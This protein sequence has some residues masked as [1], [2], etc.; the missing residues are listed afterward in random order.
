MT[1]EFTQA[2]SKLANAEEGR[3]KL[4]AFLA[5]NYELTYSEA[6]ELAE[7]K[8]YP[9]V[10][11]SQRPDVAKRQ[12]ELKNRIKA[13]GDVNVNSIEEY[14]EV[15]ERYD[16]MSA[17]IEDLQK[18]RTELEAVIYKLEEEMKASFAESFE[19]INE[20]FKKT[21][22]RLFGGGT[23]ELIL[24]EP[25][26]LLTTGIEINAAPPGKIIK[27]LSLL[28]G[29]EQ[30]F[31]AIALYFALLAVNP[32]PFILLDEIDSALDEVNVDRFGDYISEG[33]GN[34]Q[35]ILISHRRGTMESA[36]ML[37]GVTMPTKG[38]S[39][40]L[41]VNVDEIEQKIGKLN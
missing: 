15:K 13:L 14:K 39:K 30:S 1:R 29:G 20:Q 25:E 9:A 41:S 18:S 5:E 11:A 19:R 33:K 32:T 34:T 40:V 6:K 27:S 21:F 12:T 26:N 31:V 24:K 8:S 23:A 7:E 2:E 38:I 37:Y 35:F 3:T 10:T 4:T 22:T 16:F 36:D 28:S 17:Q